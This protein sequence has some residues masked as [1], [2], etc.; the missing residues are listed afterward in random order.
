LVSPDITGVDT[1]QAFRRYVVPEVEVLLRVARSITRHQEDAED[2]VQDTLLR[3]YRA[4]DRFDGEN[5]RAWLL[6]ILRNTQV[7]RN[8]RRRPTLLRD[9]EAAR[10]QAATTGGGREP[11]Q[12][13][14][15]RLLDDHLERAVCGL[16]E[17]FRR[18][19]ELVDLAGLSYEHAA[20]VLDVPVGTVMS[21]VHRGRARLRE[22]L[23]PGGAKSS[24]VKR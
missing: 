15:A 7:N 5:P 14:V 8:R 1:E 18:A 2:L 11:E 17:R 13:H 10:R 4:I 21:R 20:Y 23:R 16:P 24:E 19:V 9:P 22:Q 3:A 12:E 6:T